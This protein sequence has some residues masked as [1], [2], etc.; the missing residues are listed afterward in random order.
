[1]ADLRLAT[2]EEIKAKT[3]AP[4]GFAGPINLK[5]KGIKLIID[6]TVAAMGSMVCGGNEK[7]YHY[8][9]VKRGRD[10]N[11]DMTADIIKLKKGD[12]CA[13]C[14]GAINEQKGIEMGHVFY[15]GTKYSKAM[16]ATFLDENQKA[17]EFVMGCYGIGVTRI[18]AAAIEQG[19]DE[20]GIIWP[21]AIAPYEVYVAPVNNK[22][23]EGLDFAFELYER[24]KA[25]GID[26]IF[27]DRDISPGV[28]FKDADLIGFP[29]RVVVGEK[30][31]KDN[32]VEFKLRK[33]KNLELVGRDEVFDRV[34]AA[35]RAEKSIS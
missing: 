9:G 4:V 21:M 10:F 35:V 32:K 16:K 1:A 26:V 29:V 11:E 5:E 2:P 25:A 22:Y 24:L 28:K 18:V 33:E 34:V 30:H 15:L 12:I 13:K 8:V 14:G 17:V 3:G 27:D 31:F 7:D 19:N 23:K 6:N 20:N